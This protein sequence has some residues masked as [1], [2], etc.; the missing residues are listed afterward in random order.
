MSVFHLTCWRT[1]YPDSKSNGFPTKYDNV[2][3]AECNT[4]IAK[5]ELIT[6]PR[7]GRFHAKPNRP[8]LR[9]HGV[10]AAATP[11]EAVAAE[12]AINGEPEAHIENAKPA[13]IDAN[14]KY[15]APTPAVKADGVADVLAALIMPHLEAK[16]DAA[17]AAVDVKVL[18][19]Q[20]V[21]Q[22]QQALGDVGVRRVEVA[23]PGKPVKDMGMQH[24]QFPTLLA[25]MSAKVNIYMAGPS[26]SGKTH[27]AHA[28]ADALGVSFEYDGAT[29]H[30]STF[31]GYMSATGTYIGTKFRKQYEHGGVYAHDEADASDPNALLWL[32]AALANGH[33]SFPD[34]TVKRHPDFQCILT[35]NTW[36]AGATHEYVGRNKLDMAFLKRFA[37]I[38]WEY[39]EALEQATCGN[40]SWAKRV[41]AIRAK[42]KARGIRVLVTPRES[43]IGAQLL[44]VGMS[45][46]DVEDA[47]IR[48]GMTADQWNSVK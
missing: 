21:A 47:T 45:Q 19:A 6:W 5:G 43:Y 28:A 3:C 48:S 22:A 15:A 7:R 37:F 32:N 17:I 4:T 2:V 38:S 11:A 34:G 14:G 42:V 29:D 25:M 40:V 41:Q 24:R 10:F 12:P 9:E 39:D 30:P 27:A 35:A 36:G 8:V 13:V 33:A 44:A 46:S 31:A 26:G 23:V 1:K 20:V 18:V 16:L